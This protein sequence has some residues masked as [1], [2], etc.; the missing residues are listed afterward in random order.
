MPIVQPKVNLVEQE[1]SQKGGGDLG[2]FRK[3]LAN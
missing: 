2:S 3:T 1:R